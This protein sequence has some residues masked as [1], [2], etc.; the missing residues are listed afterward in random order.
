MR[1]MDDAAG[2][3]DSASSNNKTKKA[4]KMFIPE[5]NNALLHSS[6]H[7]FTGSTIDRGFERAH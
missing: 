3:V 6:I 1:G 2:G 4:T 7:T 5:T